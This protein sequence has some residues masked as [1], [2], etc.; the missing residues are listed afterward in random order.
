MLLAFYALDIVL[1]CPLQLPVVLLALQV[2][3]GCSPAQSDVVAAPMAAKL[4]GY[5]S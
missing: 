4:N 2:L 3:P 5:L 1:A